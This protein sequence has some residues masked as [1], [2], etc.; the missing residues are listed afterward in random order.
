MRREFYQKNYYE[1]LGVGPEAPPGEIKK[2]YRAL[3]LQFHPDRN[4]GDKAA[5]ARFKEISEAYGV[6][7]D[8]VK[9]RE[10]DSLRGGGARDGR[11]TEFHYSQEDI[12][13]DLF[14]DP[15]AR[16]I[17]ADMSHDFARMGFRFDERFL[18]HLFFGGRGVF[19]GKIIIGG[20]GGFQSR[21]FGGG[22]DFSK[23]WAKASIP[24]IER[25]FVPQGKTLKGRFFSWVG[26]KLFRGLVR[27]LLGGSLP[28]IP[29]D[30]LDLSYA[31]ALEPQEGNGGT[32]KE[33]AFF[34]GGEAKK[35]S[36]RI[37]PGTQE[38]T[39]LRLRGMGK[40]SWGK[41]GNLYLKIK[42]P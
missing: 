29:A 2:A 7:I 27:L 12:F 31:L 25:V 16:E 38:G 37:P 15:V 32:T 35:I 36:V 39:I 24:V 34:Q 42:G 33:I 41:R 9:H 30:G 14:R 40:R 5:E 18:D 23:Q 1:I 20:P 11:E 10:Y 6:L 3:A 28:R 4:P 22:Q 17:F 21:T 19:W 13:R 8:P 26:R